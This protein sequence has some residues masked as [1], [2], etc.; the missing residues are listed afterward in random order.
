[1]M[2]EICLINA[3]FGINSFMYRKVTLKWELNLVALN[4]KIL[5]VINHELSGEYIL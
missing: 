1:M 3:D 2:D 4:F 5:E